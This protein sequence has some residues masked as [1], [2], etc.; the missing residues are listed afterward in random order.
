ML[1]GLLTSVLALLS[2]PVAAAPVPGDPNGV[3]TG[4]EIEG[5]QVDDPPPAID[6]V[7]AANEIVVVDDT[8]DSGL[9]GTS[10]E[11]D[12]S[13]WVCNVGGANP[14]KNNILAAAVNAR[15]ARTPPSSTSPTPAEVGQGDAH[16]NFEFNQ[17]ATDYNCLAP[18]GFTGRTD[19]DVLLVFDFP[20][21]IGFPNIEG[22]VWDSSISADGEWVPIPNFPPGAAAG[23]EQCR[24]PSQHAL[25]CPG[26]RHPSGPDVR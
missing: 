13:G 15:I 11:N 18:G 5:N 24:P 25:R 4:F 2:P 6:W 16:V 8:L 20:G 14:G 1:V 21:G 23:A 3:L 19:G 22:F 9:S 7:T 12:P 26:A 10:K 17:N